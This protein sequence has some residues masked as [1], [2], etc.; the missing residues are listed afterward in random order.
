MRG[1]FALDEYAQLPAWQEQLCATP[2]RVGVP[3]FLGRLGRLE[4]LVAETSVKARRA[5]EVAF[6]QG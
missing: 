1:P 3:V 6:G 4:A 2:L 5:I